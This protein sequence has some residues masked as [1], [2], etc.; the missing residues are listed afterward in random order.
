MPKLQ[1]VDEYN[2]VSNK[3]NLSDE[4]KAC[5]KPVEYWSQHQYRQ[6]TYQQFAQSDLFEIA[7]LPNIVYEVKLGDALLAQ[8]ESFLDDYLYRRL[9]PACRL[10]K[11]TGGKHNRW[12]TDYDEKSKNFDPFKN[13]QVWK[14]LEEL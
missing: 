1:S 4:Q 12:T 11:I 8:E 6:I 13:R 14:V 5:F 3:L 7:I 9:K 2:W 10:G